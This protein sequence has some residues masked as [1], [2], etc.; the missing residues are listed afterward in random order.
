MKIQH[1]YER[2]YIELPSNHMLPTYQKLYPKYDRFLPNL[3][4]Y[5]DPS[6]TVIDVGAN[7][8]DTLAGMFNHNPLMNYIC[9]EPDDEFFDFLV[10]N[11]NIIRGFDG[12]LKAL[13]IKSLIG[14]DVA[15]VQL[16]GTS[17]SKHAILNVGGEINSKS[18]DLV[19]EEA[20]HTRVC[21]LKTDVDG[22]D[23]DVLNSASSTIKKYKPIIFFELQYSDAAQKNGFRET[24]ESLLSEGYNDFTIFDNFG[25]VMFRSSQIREIIQLMEY[26]WRQN[27]GLANRTIYYFDILAAV[28]PADSLVI[29]AALSNY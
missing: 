10:S 3:V 29:D 11:I 13:A 24:L 4:G 28:R 2:F 26:I 15:N 9:I 6:D 27:L 25:E 17:G 22:F 16:D 1:K 20:P 14:K 21:L 23:Y 7:V 8:G 19:I 5:L 18:L 12:R